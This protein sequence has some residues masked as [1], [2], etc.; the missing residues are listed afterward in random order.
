MNNQNL[1]TLTGIDNINAANMDDIIIRDNDLLSHCAV[2][3]ICDYLQNPNG[4]PAIIQNED[5]CNSWWEVLDICLTG[6]DE[7]DDISNKFIA[8]PN[9]FSDELNFE[10]TIH[11][12]SS[13]QITI[14]NANGV[15]LVKVEKGA[16][17]TGT[18]KLNWSASHLPNGIYLCRFTSDTGSSVVK[19]IK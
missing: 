10:I 12:P 6:S 15:E 5:G 4:A 18:H 16:F 8:Y 1:L 3:S 11:T 7:E 13:I 19:L 17:S 2:K 9:P 14:Y